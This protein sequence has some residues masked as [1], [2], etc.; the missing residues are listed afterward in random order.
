[1]KQ[2]FVVAIVAIA[3]LMSGCKDDATSV[4]PPSLGNNTVNK[5]VSIGNSLT[6][7]YESNGLS[8][9]GQKYSYPALIAQQLKI[10]GAGLNTFEQPIWG[11]PGSPNASGK[12]ARLRI[13]SWPTS[14]PVIGTTGENAGSPTNTALTRPYDNLGIPGAVISDLLDET[15]FI[16][17]AG[18]RSN[19]FFP[20]VL[21]SASFGK[22]IFEQ[23]KNITPKADVITF[24]LGNNDV[25]GFATSG[26]VNPSAPTPTTLFQ[27]W[28]AQALDSLRA[29]FPNAKIVVAN[30]PDVRSIPYFTTV[31]P[32]VAA[33]LKGAFA[34]SFQK[35]GTTGRGDGA[36]YLTEANPPLLTLASGA[37]AANISKASGKWYVDNGIPV[38]PEIDTTTMFGL[39]YRNPIPDALILDSV[40]Q[41]MAGDAIAAFNQ[42]IATVAAAKGA[43]LVDVNGIFNSIKANG[44]SA[45]GEKYTADFVSG[46]LFSLDGVHPTAKG[47]GAVANEFIKAMNNAYGMSISSVDISKLPGV[48]TVLAKYAKASLL[49]K[50]SIEESQATSRLW[51]QK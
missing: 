7:G 26:G 20:H 6:A 38:P 32:A 5:Y 3:V 15:D 24:W 28:Y 8:E 23:V 46:G 41:K 31:G 30:I 22:S 11:N 21:R 9:D 35:R 37:Y 19:P 33:N 45:G 13:L 1:M 34:I 10:A 27:T 2:N 12:A 50:I 14:G 47:A 17:K 44:L 51:N 36:S 4:P 40:E 49:P 29:A 42:T 16:A 43:L 18:A 39:D 48:P 25:L